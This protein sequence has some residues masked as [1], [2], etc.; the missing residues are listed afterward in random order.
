MSESLVETKRRIRTIQSTAKI[1]KAMKLVASVKFQKWKKIF[2]DDE[3]YRVAMHDVMVRTLQS[4]SPRDYLRQDCLK[5]FNDTKNLYIV[6]TSSL[7][8][9]G[10]YNYNI[11][12]MLD[13]ILKPDDELL[14]VGQKGYLHYKDGP[15]KLILDYLNLLDDLTYQ[16]VKKMRHYVVRKYRGGG[17]RS[18]TLVYTIFKNSLAVVP[19]VKRMLPFDLEHY[20]L[21][22]NVPD[23][24]PIF[25]P[26]AGEVLRLILPHYLD[27][28]F[29]N[30]FL[31]SEV[32]EQSSRRNAMET[33]TDSANDLMDKLKIIYN[34]SRQESITQEITEVIAGATASKKQY[35]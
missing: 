3:A 18:V 13:P 2:D 22:Q 5:T 35:D 25:D 17:Y 24:K 19:T 26:N 10:S 21:D 11:F 32:S 34:K 12:K 23:Y 16:N 8:L 15:Y 31:M 30:K 28:S 20:H 29:Y 14:L 33:A 27:A 1:T 6:V 9:C 7:G 4:I